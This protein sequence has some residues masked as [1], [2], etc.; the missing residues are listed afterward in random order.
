MRAGATTAC[1][2][3][4]RTTSA[5]RCSTSTQAASTPVRT[6]SGALLWAGAASAGPDEDAVRHLLHTTFDK[7]EARVVVDPVAVADGYA[8]AGWTQGEMGGRALLRHRQG[9][10][11]LIL[12][13][14]DGIRTPKH[15]GKQVSRRTP[16]NRSRGNWQKRNASRL[17][18]G[19]RCSQDLKGS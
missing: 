7:P 12:C 3:Y 4:R 15:F 14:G 11:A 8:L 17:P 2:A 9:R 5:P 1:L 6:S 16:R 18:N 19:L 13:A 10:W